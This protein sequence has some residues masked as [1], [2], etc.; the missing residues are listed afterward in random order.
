MSLNNSI[1]IN[2]ITARD[3]RHI[4]IGGGQV[5]ASGLNQYGTLGVG[6]DYASDS[7]HGTDVN[8]VWEAPVLPAEHGIFYSDKD[9]I[10]Y[11]A[12]T[13]F[14]PADVVSVR[15]AGTSTFFITKQGNLYAC[16][17]NNYGQL[18]LGWSDDSLS[19]FSHVELHVPD[20]T[21]NSP[22]DESHVCH[23]R[24]CIESGYY[25]MSHEMVGNT[26]VPITDVVD[27]AIFNESTF[28]LKKDGTVVQVGRATELIDNGANAVT[29][30]P[31]DVMCYH[32]DNLGTADQSTAVPITNIVK[33]HACSARRTVFFITKDGNVYKAGKNEKG[34]HLT[35]DTLNV[36]EALRSQGG[37]GMRFT[38]EHL[39]SDIVDVAAG[40]KHA[41]YLKKDGTVYSTC[42]DSAYRGA[43]GYGS[44]ISSSVFPVN[45][46]TPVMAPMESGSYG[47]FPATFEDIE[48][49]TNAIKI[50][51]QD[52][53]SYILGKDTFLYTFGEGRDGQLGQ[54]KEIEQVSYPDNQ[55]HPTRV[56]SYGSYSNYGA[57]NSN[58]MQLNSISDF[59]LGHK[60]LVITR[61]HPMFLTYG[62][63][64]CGSNAYNGVTNGGYMENVIYTAPN[65]W[66]SN[67]GYSVMN[68]TEIDPTDNPPAIYPL[69]KENDEVYVSGNIASAK[70]KSSSQEIT[71]TEDGPFKT[72]SMPAEDVVVAEPIA[73]EYTAPLA[74]NE[75]DKNLE[76]LW[77]EPGTFTMGQNDINYASP[78]AVTLTEG[79]Y[80][81]KYEVTQA[82]YEAVMT[83]NTDG[84]NATPSNFSG[85]PNRPV[86]QVSHDDIQ[87]FLTRLNAQEAGNISAGWA[88]VLPTEAQWEYACRAGTT[89][90]YSTGDTISTSDANYGGTI[91]ETTD[92][93]SYS[94]NPWGF[95]DMHGNV[96]EWT[97]DWYDWYSSDAQTDPEGP[98]TGDKRVMRGGSWQYPD[99]YSRSAYRTIRTPDNQ[100]NNVGFRIALIK[101]S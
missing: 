1:N 75:T 48:V 36:A 90:V 34:S 44:R 37:D 71:L 3:G 45:Y 32:I 93:G 91:N 94:A 88:Y 23:P 39:L 100:S 4:R 95:F 101:I 59:F 6:Y 42:S 56:L 46:A 16:G 40:V 41:L 31:V 84:L 63:L 86:E 55:F 47:D 82:Q 53:N 33:I 81:G 68:S 77:V 8:T 54:G 49:F 15:N 12:L 14:N 73:T 80:L 64:F 61:R 57:L 60:Y 11:T 18:A 99:S 89:T 26:I 35:D 96:F 51:V 67:G 58:S 5:I 78:H 43:C 76:M 97:A 28:I 65:A 69:Y 2:T 25:Y 87:K 10:N 29:T 70:G 38:N 85:N 62:Y 92:V 21:T 83:G 52:G 50:G 30:Y 13:E 20:G 66:P 74:L 98:A 9:H 22:I 27:V 24:Q 19:T 79:F 7:S 72:F 17:R